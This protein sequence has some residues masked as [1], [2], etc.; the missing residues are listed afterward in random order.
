MIKWM[1]AVL[2]F[3][4][5]SVPAH[6]ELERTLW[7]WD[8]QT[9][10]QGNFSVSVGGGYENYNYL[11]VDGRTVQSTAALSY[12][13]RDN[14]S[15][16]LEV[17]YQYWWEKGYGEKYSEKG[18]GD[19]ALVTTY[20]FINDRQSSVEFAVR[21]SLNVPT[22]DDDRYLGSGKWEPKLEFITASS[23]GPVVLVTNLGGT[24]IIDADDQEEHVVLN[25]DIECVVPLTSWLSANAVV[26]GWTSRWE[27]SADDHYLQLG[28]GVRVAP[29]AQTFIAAS[30]YH[31][32][33]SDF[34]DDDWYVMLNLG[35]E[36]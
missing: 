12:G 28:G 30:L 19:S 22:G 6:A 3:C 29:T 17:S 4:V 36:F 16:G 8:T 1:L 33:A 18:L 34:Y 26:S 13:I 2:V 7:A 35:A 31:L 14:W 23:L 11:K 21:G 9:P 27:E 20:R 10:Q 15:A 24:Y 25:G 32:V 5:F